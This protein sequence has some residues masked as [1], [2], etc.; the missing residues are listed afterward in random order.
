MEEQT[1]SLAATEGGNH[2]GCP[3]SALRLSQH[4]P[5]EASPSCSLPPS[6]L[7]SLGHPV[8]MGGD[9]PGITPCCPWGTS[10]TANPRACVGA[11]AQGR[12]AGTLARWDLLT[13]SLPLAMDRESGEW[14]LHSKLGLAL[15]ASRSRTTSLAHWAGREAGGRRVT[16]APPRQVRHTP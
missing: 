11:G 5:G 4:L 12:H 14:P 16:G 10:R 15:W 13:R 6:T 2:P 1:R 9:R 7:L 8:L 3:P